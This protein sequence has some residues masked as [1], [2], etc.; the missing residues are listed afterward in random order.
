MNL[1]GIVG[2]VGPFAGLDLT[3]KIFTQTLAG[4]DQEH[5]PVALLSVPGRIADRT[6]YLLGRVKDNPAS[7]V[8]DII[9]QLEKMGATVV[10]IPC[11]TMHADP[12][13]G[14]IEKNLQEKGSS[15]RL[16]NM[17]SE[18]ASFIATEFQGLEKIGILS[19]TG[20][21][22]T[23]IYG[24]ALEGNGLIPV[25]PLQDAQ[26][27]IHAAV[28]DGSYGIKA[29]SHPVTQQARN[30]LVR[31]TRHLK[32]RGAQAIILGCTEISYALPHQMLEDLPLFD[33]TAILAR[34][35]IAQSYPEKLK[36]LKECGFDFNAISGR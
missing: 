16:L 6:R 28:Y 30:Q 7:A 29:R 23:G 4:R 20:T 8:T 17:I 21:W 26:Q 24:R 13:F 5:L 3:T 9:L 36:P 18:V 31:G 19:T 32:D 34:S 12:I 10:G 1:I 22:E 14:V 27:Q 35:L 33:A 15:I 11:N 25:S 2:G